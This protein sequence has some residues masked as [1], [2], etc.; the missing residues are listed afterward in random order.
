[1][2]PQGLYVLL[3]FKLLKRVSGC[4][5]VILKVMKKAFKAKELKSELKA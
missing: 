3:S 2:P 5:F 1:M 4:C